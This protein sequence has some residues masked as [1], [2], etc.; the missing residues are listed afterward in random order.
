[1]RARRERPR[2]PVR[3]AE[4]GLKGASGRAAAARE[5]GKEWRGLRQ[6]AVAAAYRRLAGGMPAPAGWCLTLNLGSVTMIYNSQLDLFHIPNGKMYICTICREPLQL[7][8]KY[9][10]SI[11]SY[12]YLPPISVA[13]PRIPRARHHFIRPA[14]ANAVTVEEDSRAIA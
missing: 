1:M 10:K 11:H 6:P 7:E 3:T 13:S 2:W 4:R 14:R 12:I 8:G 5:G 9:E